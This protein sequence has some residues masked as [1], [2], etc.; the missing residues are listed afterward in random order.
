MRKERRAAKEEMF[1]VEE[2]L[3]ELKEMTRSMK[4][5]LQALEV[6]GI[7]LDFMYPPQ[8]MLTFGLLCLPPRNKD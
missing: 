3:D 8:E 4:S 5:R 2:E 7:R 6:R 1:A